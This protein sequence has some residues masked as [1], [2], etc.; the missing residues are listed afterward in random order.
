MPGALGATEAAGVA[1]AALVHTLYG[2]IGIHDDGVADGDGRDAGRR[3]PAADRSRPRPDRPPRAAPRPRRRRARRVAAVTGHRPGTVGA[4]RPLRRTGVR[5]HRRRTGARRRRAAAGGR[6]VG[7]DRH[8]RARSAR[9]RPGRALRRA[10]AR[11]GHR[12]RP[13]RPGDSRRTVERLGAPA[14]P[15]R[16]VVPGASVVVCHAGLGTIM[17]ALRHG[18]PVLCIPLGR[19]QHANAAAVVAAGVGRALD[20]DASPTRSGRPWAPWRRAVRNG[21]PPCGWPPP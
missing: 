21:P 3:Q 19:D 9:T 7:N 11:A 5:A 13:P 17:A 6:L 15:P 20:R 14:D 18:V 2:R 16:A 1:T 8:G 12:R 4:Q 10:Q